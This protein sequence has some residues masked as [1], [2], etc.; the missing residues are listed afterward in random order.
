MLVAAGLLRLNGVSAWN[1]IA[2]CVL[3]SVPIYCAL[4][5][6]KRKFDFHGNCLPT[7]AEKVTIKLGCR[8]WINWIHGFAAEAIETASR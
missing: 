4:R 7:G 1:L 2:A 6:P 5:F 3:P 8:Y